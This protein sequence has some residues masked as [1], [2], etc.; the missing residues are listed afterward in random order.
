MVS[1]PMEGMIKLPGGGFDLKLL[2]GKDHSQIRE[3]EKMQ[4][5]NHRNQN[6]DVETGHGDYSNIEY[7]VDIQM[8]DDSKLDRAPKWLRIE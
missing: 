2:A 8:L 6:D 3:F 4:A 7:T 1:D 5:L